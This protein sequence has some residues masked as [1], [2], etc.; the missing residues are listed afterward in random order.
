MFNY[1]NDSYLLTAIC[2]ITT[3]KTD[4]KPFGKAEQKQNTKYSTLGKAEI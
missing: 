2:I 3:N 4:Q 1:L